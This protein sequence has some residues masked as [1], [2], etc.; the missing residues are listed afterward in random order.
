MVKFT[1]IFSLI[2]LIC[3]LSLLMKAFRIILFSILE[4]FLFSSSS[5]SCFFRLV[6]PTG[7]FL[8]SLSKYCSKYTLAAVVFSMVN[9]E[10]ANRSLSSLGDFDEFPLFCDFSILV[11]EVLITNLFSFLSLLD[12]FFF[13][14]SFLIYTLKLFLKIL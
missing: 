9:G 13:F 12:S 7:P 6:L 10:I 1:P 14:Y 5:S 8:Y 4:I 3:I 2:L 11:E